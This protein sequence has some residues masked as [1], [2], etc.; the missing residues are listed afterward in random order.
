MAAPGAAIKKRVVDFD[1]AKLPV[2]VI[3][4]PEL[5]QRNIANLLEDKGRGMALLSFDESGGLL[6]F[7][8]E[9]ELYSSRHIEVSLSQL[10]ESDSE[11]RQ[12]HFDR[13]T[14][15]LQRSMDHFERQFAFITISKLMLAALPEAVNLE[16]YLS[17]NLYIPVATLSLDD[18]FDFS[19]L[20]GA[21]PDIRQRCFYAL[22]AA[23]RDESV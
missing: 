6:T 17:S 14:L 5:A 23:L 19:L 2:S 22:G 9:G 12:R 4:I 7:T 8:F 10:S 15:E 3:D 18:I 11:Q 21:T 16:A 1:A 20:P 13:I